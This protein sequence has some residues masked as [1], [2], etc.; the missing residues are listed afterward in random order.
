MKIIVYV[1]IDENANEMLV[2]WKIAFAEHGIKK[3]G[4]IDFHKGF[5]AAQEE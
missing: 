5:K 1:T 2:A 4:Y 3:I